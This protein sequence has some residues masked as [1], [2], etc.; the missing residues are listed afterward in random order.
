MVRSRGYAAMVVFLD[1]QLLRFSADEV[2]V[3]NTG[4]DTDYYLLFFA[5]IVLYQ[6]L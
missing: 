2:I 1:L 5:A 6:L 4:D 3:H